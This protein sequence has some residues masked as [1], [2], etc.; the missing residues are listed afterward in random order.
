MLLSLVM[1]SCAYGAQLDPRFAKNV[2]LYHVNQRNYSVAPRNMNT[3]DVNGDIY[4]DLRTKALPLECGPWKDMSFWSRIDCVNGEVNVDPKLLAVTKLV[5]EVDTRY[6][7]YAD[8]NLNTDTGDYECDCENVPDN[9]T[10]LNVHD[11]GKKCNNSNGCAWDSLDQRCESYGCPNITDQS[12][13]TQGYRKCVWS[14]SGVCHDP[15]GL[16]P[17]C[18]ATLVGFLNLSNVNWGRH[19]HSGQHLSPID[20]WHGNTLS[21][22][23]GFWYSTDADGECR[24][25][26]PHQ[27]FCSWRLVGLVKKVAKDCSD[28]KIDNTIIDGD[29]TAPWGARCYDHCSPSDFHNK[30]SECWI[31]CFYNNV[32]GPNG[33]SRL[34]NHS[35]LGFGIPLPQL[36]AAWDKPFLSE[37]NG[38][39]PSL[40]L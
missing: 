37:E 31:R 1:I 27:T 19:A 9:C 23:N 15:P 40:S 4:F 30:S 8:C 21:K 36:Q 6:G 33:T 5:L 7:D 2:T 22:T 3:A 38:G 25:D 24:D 26:D 35:D 10:A 18:N 13:C 16:P 28:D 34:M 17:V 11:G 12:D 29:R 32:L 39:C 20:Y 14:T